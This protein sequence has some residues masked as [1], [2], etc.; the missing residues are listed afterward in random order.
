[1]KQSLEV[2]AN[3][4]VNPN[5]GMANDYLNHFNEILLLVENL[6]ALLPEMV[7]DILEWEPIGYEDY[8]QNSVL[9][10]KDHVLEVYAAL[11]EEFRQD[12]ENM[13]HLMNSIVLRS[14]T[15]I[16]DN[17]KPDGTLD[18]EDL[19]LVCGELAADMRTVLDRTAD[20]INHG[21]APPLERPQEMAD[22]IMAAQSR[23]D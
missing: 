2:R 5:S 1:M 13:V 14:I 10:G 4:L 22:R 21:Y 3:N 17:R 11:D 7:D 15:V 18:P 9:P 19:G 8:F 20:L 12:F 6:P 16:A 23:D